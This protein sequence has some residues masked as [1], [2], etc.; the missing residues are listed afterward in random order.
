ML[1]LIMRM[2]DKKIETLMRELLKE[3]GVD[4]NSEAFSNTPKRVARAYREI[5]AGLDD[6][7]LPKVTTFANPGYKDILSVKD[8]PFY[9]MCEHHILPFF[10][11]VSIAYIPGNKII[12]LSKIPRIIKFFSAKLQVQERLTKEIA[13]FLYKNL[14][15]KGVLVVIKARHMCMEMRGVKSIGSETRSSAVRGAFRTSGETRSEA[16]RLILGD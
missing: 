11:T 2:D 3:I 12:G 1:S 15:A 5:F 7:N 4:K 9:S 16:L 13:D 14:K 8:I 6:G 10:G